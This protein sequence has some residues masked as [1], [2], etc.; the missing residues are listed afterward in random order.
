MKDEASDDRHSREGGKPVIPCVLVS[1]LRGNDKVGNREFISALF[2][3]R[4]TD[5]GLLH[6]LTEQGCLARRKRL[7]DV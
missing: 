5:S 6:M 4:L 1:R 7:W 2:Q 3:K